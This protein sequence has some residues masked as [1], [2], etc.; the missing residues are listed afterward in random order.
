VL[1]F[2]HL[3]DLAHLAELAE[4][5]EEPRERAAA[6]AGR[7]SEPPPSSPRRRTMKLARCCSLSLIGSTMALALAGCGPQ[8]TQVKRDDS[9]VDLSGEWNDVD[10]DL[11][12]KEMIQ[13]CMSSP[14]ADKFKQKNGRGPVVKLYPIKNKSSDHVETKYFTKQVEKALVNSGNIEVV[15]AS[16]EADVTRQ[17]QADQGS[18]ASDESA[19][20]ETGADFIMSGWVVSQN[21]SDGGGKVIKAFVTTMELTDVQSQ[22]KV[23]LDDKKIKKQVTRASMSF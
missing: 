12:A 1:R 22:K 20:N 13:D 4:L 8:G 5:D 17:E 14:W 2:V 21:D 11:V 10:A 6:A 19:G 9:A 16:D 18:H 3:A 23:W 7:P 15:A